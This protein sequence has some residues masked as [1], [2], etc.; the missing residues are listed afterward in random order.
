MPEEH[1]EKEEKNKGG[2]DDRDR[3]R[4]WAPRSFRLSPANTHF[5]GYQNQVLSVQG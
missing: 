2:D 4:G 5:R 3:S 1:R